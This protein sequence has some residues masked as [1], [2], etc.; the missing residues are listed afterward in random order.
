M[1]FDSAHPQFFPM[2]FYYSANLTGKEMKTGTAPWAFA[3]T[4]TLGD[5]L[6][7]DKSARQAWYKNPATQHYFYTLIEAANPN[8]RPSK[9]NPPKF[10]WGIPLDYDL[11]LPEEQVFAAA[12]GM[13]IPPTWVERSLGGNWRLVWLFSSPL[14]VESYDFCAYLLTQAVKWLD[15][16]ALPGLDEGAATDPARLLCNGCQ[17]TEVGPCV[18]DDV[19]QAFFVATGKGYRFKPSEGN[20]IPLD[21]VEKEILVRFPGFSWPSDF[22][23][24][25]Q[26]PSFWIA[27]STTPLSAIVK[28][29]G[30]FTFSGHAAKPFYSWTE[31]LGA[32]F[33][34]NFSVKSIAEAT[35]EIYWDSKRF[36][37]KIGGVYSSLDSPELQNYFKVTCRLSTK[38]GKEGHSPVDLA[39][40]HIYNNGRI[41][42]AAPHLF[43]APGLLEY[44]G[45][46]VLN[47][48]IPRV[49]APADDCT[50]WGAEG[51]FPFLS[52]H[53]D[54]LFDPAEQKWHFLAWWKA[55]YQSGRSLLPMPGQNIF[56]MGGV[57]VGKTLTS[58]AIIGKSIGGF[59]DASAFLINGGGFNSELLCM[60]LWCVDDETMGESS[61]SQTNFNAML[62]KTAANQS[63]QHNKKFEVGTTT[64][65]SGR[66]VVTTNL[67]YI[68]SR[69]LGPMDNGSADK[70]CVFRCASQGKITFPNRHVLA[71]LIE[72]ELPYFLRW[73]LEYDPTERGVAEDVRYGYA[74][75]HEPS[76]LDQAQQG[77]KA[78]PFKELL[79]EAL[80]EYFVDNPKTAQWRG[81]LTQLVR[82]MHSN[83]MNDAVLRAMKL[84]QTNRY[85]EMVQ[86]EDCISCSVEPGP[87]RTRI[88]VF[89][90]FGTSP[91]V[92]QPKTATPAPAINIFTK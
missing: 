29:E 67:D 8:M 90:R 79:Y 43:R 52:Q 39:L 22:V 75:Y 34:K 65:W 14:N 64:S 58:R 62:K 89:N 54:A 13:K 36:W 5:E 78:A 20:E 69:A 68:S 92:P 26:G 19:V 11:P 35:K 16:D 51:G 18:P 59:C 31:I 70:T 55:F 56:L 66:I 32:D 87:L 41:A 71:G 86:R 42:G 81:S 45:Q 4:E 3:P 27:A 9:D 60:P 33:A 50:P 77:S 17:W 84:E 48:Y 63:F 82:L 37:R 46:R 47:T 24:G 38:P 10:Q 53:F 61:A 25:S 57:N 1:P 28:P 21:L 85:L 91:E 49:C 7:K 88:W 30:M 6:R 80:T 72:K 23:V 2:K 40:D 73:L 83:P 74:A 44:Q 76:L 15:H 12:R